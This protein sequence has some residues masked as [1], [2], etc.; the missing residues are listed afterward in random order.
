M[1]SDYQKTFDLVIE[2][3]KKELVV[4]LSGK[5]DPTNKLIVPSP[6]DLVADMYN[7]MSQLKIASSL[8]KTRGHHIKI[9]DISVKEQYFLL[10]GF[11]FLLDTF[12]SYIGDSKIF[13]T[14]HEA[15]QWIL[16]ECLYGF[17][18][19][20]KANQEFVNRMIFFFENIFQGYDLSKFK[21]HMLKSSNKGNFMKKFDIVIGNPPYNG[22][23]QGGGAG[24]GNPV[25]YKHVE[26]AFKLVR[27]DGY[28]CLIHPIGWRLDMNR[29]RIMKA[30]HLLFE[31]Q[32]LYLKVFIPFGE[33]V[34]AIVDWYVCQKRKAT[35]LTTVQ[36]LNGQ[37]QYKV[38][39][40]IRPIPHYSS[41][42]IDEILGAIF[43]I[44]NNGLFAR[45]VRGG[46]CVLNEEYKGKETNFPFVKGKNYLDGEF[47][48]HS[49]PHI[50][51]FF[52]KVYWSDSRQPHPKFDPGKGDV[53]I[54]DHIHYLPLSKNLKTAEVE[55]QFLIPII[56]GEVGTFL[57]KIF[58]PTFWDGKDCHWNNP[59][60]FSRIMIV[61]KALNG[62]QD[63][64]THFGI[65]KYAT[66][67]KGVINDK[68]ETE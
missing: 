27:D 17:Y 68:Q 19:F 10:F 33:K 4:G 29:K 24:S 62:D 8:K 56:V 20:K 15:I 42:E 61:P 1:K 44:E 30:Q 7:I 32:M 13:K 54:D 36:F 12:Q 22:R 59:Y 49:K 25:W 9:A 37:R 50:H 11:G 18:D 38:Y 48:H 2:F 58:A 55:A 16:S 26:M 47:V 45:K 63:V 65:Q 57:Q 21:K 14:E 52:P 51:Q 34:G 67:I 53:G 66:Y 5:Q 40:D 23:K 39:G 60:P 41:E 64:Y 31:N 46:L 28:V 35:D 43:T 6:L 3:F